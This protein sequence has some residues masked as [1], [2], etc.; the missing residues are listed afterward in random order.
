M[1][2]GLFPC[3]SHG[4]S[5][6]SGNSFVHT[7]CYYPALTIIHNILSILLR[8]HTA[9]I[10]LQK[11]PSC[12][13]SEILHP[14]ST[15]LPQ[16]HGHHRFGSPWSA[17]RVPAR[18]QLQLQSQFTCRQQPPGQQNWSRPC[19]AVLLW[20]R[21]SRPCGKNWT[22]SQTQQ[23]RQSRATVWLAAWQSSTYSSRHLSRPAAGQHSTTA[24][25]RQLRTQQHSPQSCCFTCR[26]GWQP[27]SRHW[28]QSA[29]HT[30][31]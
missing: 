25:A 24:A 7:R 20:S 13:P 3:Y 5:R 21:K 31:H 12:S 17:T 26:R 1:S 22:A 15:R 2:Q 19:K 30:R 6:V 29:A 27:C 28:T 18:P 9:P 10:V 14:E 11:H 23:Q 4:C 8:H 16:T